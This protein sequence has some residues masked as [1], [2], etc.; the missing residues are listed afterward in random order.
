MK[1]LLILSL[2][3]G[4]MLLSLSSTALA[5]PVN[6]LSTSVSMEAAQ[7]TVQDIAM[8]TSY[9]VTWLAE[10]WMYP[11]VLFYDNQSCPDVTY[12]NDFIAMWCSGIM[13]A[14]WFM[15]WIYQDNTLIS[16]G[17]WPNGMIMPDGPIDPN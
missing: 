15:W 12:V 2:M 4:C 1:K 16:W 8:P 14:K 5:P 10:M 17:S 3:M 7:A 9:H 11:N 6:N 13:G